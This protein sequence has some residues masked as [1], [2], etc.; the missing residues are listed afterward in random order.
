MCGPGFLLTPFRAVHVPCVV[1]HAK[2][3]PARLTFSALQLALVVALVAEHR[4]KLDN[5]LCDIE[6]DV[7]KLKVGTI[8]K[9]QIETKARIQVRWSGVIT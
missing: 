4:V 7:L 3:L 2:F 8:K 9:V 5:F 1:S 6:L